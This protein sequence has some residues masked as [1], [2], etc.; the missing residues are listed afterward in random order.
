[1]KKLIQLRVMG[2][3]RAIEQLILCFARQETTHVIYQQVLTAITLPKDFRLKDETE[4]IE[5]VVKPEAMQTD[6]EFDLTQWQER[7]IESNPS[8]DMHLYVEDEQANVCHYYSE[9]ESVTVEE[10]LI[11]KDVEELPTD[12]DFMTH[13]LFEQFNNLF[14]DVSDTMDETTAPVVDEAL[15]NQIETNVLSAISNLTTN[16]FG[17]SFDSEE[18]DTKEEAFTPDKTSPLNNQHV[19][20]T[21]QIK[22]STALTDS[23]VHQLFTLMDDLFSEA[24]P[25]NQ[26]EEKT[27]DQDLTQPDEVIAFASSLDDFH[28]DIEELNEADFDEED[29]LFTR[30]SFE[31]EDEKVE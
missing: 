7:V 28:L 15:L 18:G 16:L 12:N 2:S 31:T 19:N 3:K 9:K 14:Q 17:L 1:M 6:W 24:T 20:M 8:L 25:L 27:Q 11:M 5:L 29:I 4:L 10:F 13:H 22:K 30:D 26:T 21:T 23:T